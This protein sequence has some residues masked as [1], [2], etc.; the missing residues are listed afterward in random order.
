[1]NNFA[2]GA[3]IVTYNP[4]NEFYDLIKSLGKDKVFVVVV[5]NCSSEPLRIDGED[6]LLI[7]NAKNVGLA[8]ALNQ[9]CRVLKDKKFTHAFT[10]DQD[11]K[12]NSDSISQLIDTI[13][14]Y[15]NSAIICPRVLLKNG[16]AFMEGKY[17]LKQNK[18]F[19]RT[20]I[21]GKNIVNLFCNITSGSL[22]NLSIWEEIGYFWEALF[23]EQIDN[24]YALRCNYFGYDIILNPKAFIVQQLGDYSGV[25]RR[26][27]ITFH[28]TN[29]SP[30][31]YWY[32]FRNMVLVKK[33][34]RGL[35]KKYF[36]Y[37]KL[38]YFKKRVTIF[39][40][41]ADSKDKLRAIRLGKKAAHEMKVAHIKNEKKTPLH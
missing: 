6:V 30:K 3:V 19:I 24:E 5:D 35:F 40:A 20:K 16:D 23:I 14:Q 36:L 10:F 21:D 28:P 4:S 41:E 37:I 2:V 7:N 12:I 34:Y 38:A 31:R 18:S 9:G 39:L 1:M 27:G 11:T 25:V 29:H 22:V 15:P 8:A 17:L 33:R 26:F 32:Q 13:A